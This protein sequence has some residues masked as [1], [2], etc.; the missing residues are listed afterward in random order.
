[1][2]SKMFW[3]KKK[4]WKIGDKFKIESMDTLYVVTDVGSRVV[5]A[6]KYKEDWMDGPPFG[7]VEKV[8]D[9]D[10]QQVMVKV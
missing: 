7:V 9:E 6:V 8:F 3:K 2:L 1:M 4:S 5:V 10:D